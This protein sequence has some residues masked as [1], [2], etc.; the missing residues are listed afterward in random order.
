MYLFGYESLQEISKS[1]KNSPNTTKFW[2]KKLFLVL[3]HYQDDII[4]WGKVWIDETYFKVIK[5][6]V[7]LRNDAKEFRGL[8]KIK[9]V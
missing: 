7:K 8:P 1:N 3:E 2:I 9:S 5:K 4:L 6:D